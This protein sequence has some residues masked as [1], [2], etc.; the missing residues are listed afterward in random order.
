MEN[1]KSGFITLVTGSMFSGK[2]EELMRTLR[3]FEIAKQKVV[4]FKPQID[5]R[6]DAEKV[7]S[8]NGDA[9]FAVVKKI[10]KK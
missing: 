10:L 5:N 8:H 2:T 6:Y 9:I 7:V 4:L 1:F 3:R